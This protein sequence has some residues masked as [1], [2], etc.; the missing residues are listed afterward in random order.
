MIWN[1]STSNQTYDEWG[2][3]LVYGTHARTNKLFERD[4]AW[5]TNQTMV[6]F[7]VRFFGGALLSDVGFFLVCVSF[8]PCL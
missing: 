1:S 7:G 8:W 4:C 2:S 5:V 6:L 3:F